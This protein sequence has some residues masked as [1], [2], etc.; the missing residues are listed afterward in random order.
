MIVKDTLKILI[1]IKYDLHFIV[2]GILKRSNESKSILLSKL[3]LISTKNL[4]C[5]NFQEN[6]VNQQKACPR[7]LF[8]KM[9]HFSQQHS[10]PS[11]QSYLYPS[12]SPHISPLPFL[13]SNQP[14][15]HPSPNP[16]PTPTPPTPKPLP[17]PWFTLLLFTA[18]PTPI[19]PSCVTSNNVQRLEDYLLLMMQ[20]YWLRLRVGVDGEVKGW[21]RGG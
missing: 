6:F 11:L 16:P 12:K 19:F 9:A 10:N 4:S 17:P 1:I 13:T 7:C 8:F 18:I 21:R 2:L 3:C 14:I 15:P 5:N 20:W